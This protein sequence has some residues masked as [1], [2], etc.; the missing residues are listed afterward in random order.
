MCWIKGGHKLTLLPLAVSLPLKLGMFY[1]C[2]HQQNT[3][4]VTPSQ[5]QAQILRNKGLP[6]LVP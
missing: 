2:V 1:N 5:G 4:R 3:A 6:L